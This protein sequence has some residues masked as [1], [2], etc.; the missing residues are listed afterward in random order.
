MAPPSAFA[1][2]AAE[3]PELLEHQAQ[4]LPQ[5]LAPVIAHLQRLAPPLV[6]SIARGSSDHAAAFAGYELT[7]RL[8]VPAFALPLSIASVYAA[9][10][11][12]DRALAL[13]VSQSGA[14]PDLTA[15]VQSVRRD[16]AW[17]L[18][19]LN[20]TASALAAA[21]DAVLPLGA[22]PERAVAATKSFVLSATALLQLVAAWAGDAVLQASLTALPS[23][24]RANGPATIPADAIDTLARTTHAFVIAR[25]SAL[26]IA[27]E[28]ALKLG[29]VAGIHAEAHSA[30]ALLHGPIARV[31]PSTPAIV[32][33]GDR[34][35]ALSLQEA[36]VRLREAGAPVIALGPIDDANPPTER[37]P[38]EAAPHAALQPL[39]DLHA[40]Y[41]LL[42]LLAQR[43]GIDPDRSPHLAK[44]TRTL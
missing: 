12:L 27:R 22:G 19:V 37:F 35:T 31:S 32:F 16:G 14:S 4:Q 34:D 40:T 23:V 1:R 30:A 3:I 10:M 15:A 9:P 39:V 42:A 29:E 2:E 18:G 28:L 5:L 43:R 33:G 24:L 6:V 44:A 17:T 7:R 38:T 26:P 20:E 13:T 11:R 36:K 21:V 41:P 8:G 25:G